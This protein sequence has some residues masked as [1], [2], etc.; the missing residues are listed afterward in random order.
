MIL[1][2]LIVPVSL[3]ETAVSIIA[4]TIITVTIVTT[5]TI[6]ITDIIAA[7]RMG[8]RTTKV[9]KAV[10]VAVSIKRVILARKRITPS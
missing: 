10:T 5:V 8:T 3:M 9:R 7:V 2:T 6:V 4:I 1:L